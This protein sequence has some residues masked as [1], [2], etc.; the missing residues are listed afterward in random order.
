MRV[1]NWLRPL[2]ARLNHTPARPAARHPR[3]RLQVEG[4]EDRTTPSTVQLTDTPFVVGPHYLTPVGS[5]MYF[6]AD[7]GSGSELWRTDGLPGDA[8]PV[9]SGSAPVDPGNPGST[10]QP[11]NHFQQVAHVGS[12]LYFFS[13]NSDGTYTLW[14]N[15]SAVS[16]TGGTSPSEAIQTIPADPDTFGPYQLTAVGHDIYYG[17][18]SG[19]G[20]WQLWKMAGADGAN[21][22]VAPF[23]YTGSDSNGPDTI[24]TAGGSLYFAADAPGNTAEIVLWGSG[25]T[26]AGTAPILD[27]NNNYVPADG[28]VGST[29]FATVG[30]DLYVI[31]S[32]IGNGAPGTL[33]RISSPTARPPNRSR[34]S[35]ALPKPSVRASSTT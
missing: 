33:W 2:A 6:V 20:V 7:A 34:R 30:S 11:A 29:N 3:F 16:P 17:A 26:L 4:L 12:W 5:T 32:D 25:G 31:T 13:D 21:P 24:K 14:R 8:V 18:Y 10:F 23:L 27:G 19:D 22:I 1:P 15:N 35:V 9:E 28:Y